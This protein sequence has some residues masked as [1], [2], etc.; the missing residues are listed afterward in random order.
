MTAMRGLRPEGFAFTVLLGAMAA[1]PPL[2]IDMGL[3]AFPALERGLHTSAAGAGLTLSLFLGG[4]AAAQLLLGPLAD[5]LGRRPVLLGGLMLY[6]LAGLVCA[7]SPSIGFLLGARLV[8]GLCAASGS[9]MALAIVR[10]RFE[11]A[12]ARARLSY[13]SVVLSVAPIVAPSIGGAAVMLA[14][15]RGVYAFLGI[16]GG[17]L[18]LA[19]ALGLEET[20]PEAHVP[21]RVAAA[22]G[23]MLRHRRAIG[24]ALTNALG[25]GAM[26]AYIAGSP[27]VLMGGF[28]LSAPVYALLFAVNAAGIMAGAWLNGRLAARGVA[29]RRPLAS[30]LVAGLAAAAALLAVIGLG[31]GSLG[32]VMGLLVAFCFTR[33]LI[34]PNA[35]HA[36]IEPMAEIAGVAAAVIGFLQMMTGALASFVVGALFVRLG[37]LAMP[38]AMTVFS[39]AALLAWWLAETAPRG[40]DAPASVR[41]E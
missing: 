33:G 24:F 5:R 7:A 32:A 21:P 26:F 10:D 2:S 11:G 29:P 13:V 27:L 19:V 25:F 17:L 37:A 1:L 12:A 31:A 35:T 6:A 30:A 41:G 28:G 20:R 23:R 9:V 36:A 38:L 14:G 18:T 39:I 3:P 8:Q 34:M 16:A 15:W 22:F 40:A 4:F